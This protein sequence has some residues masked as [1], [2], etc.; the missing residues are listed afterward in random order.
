MA[1]SHEQKSVVIAS[2]LGWTLDAFDFFLMIFVLK[3]IAKEFNTSIGSVTIAITATLI[4]R[5]VGAIIFGRLADKFGRKPILMLNIICFSLF[6][7]LSGFAPSLVT[8]LIIRCLFGIAM[9]GVNGE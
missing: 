4:L 7:L 5:P 3:D 9:G 6:E 2:Y 1:W 8:L